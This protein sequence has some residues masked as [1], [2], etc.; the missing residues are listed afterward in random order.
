ME[1]AASRPRTGLNSGVSERNSWLSEFVDLDAAR[2]RSR[3]DRQRD[4]DQEAR[5]REAQR[6]EADPLDAVGERMELSPAPGG[7]SV[8]GSCPLDSVDKRPPEAL[9]VRAKDRDFFNVEVKPAIN[10]EVKPAIRSAP[11]QKPR[12]CHLVACGEGQIQAAWQAQG[13]SRI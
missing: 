6:D 1:S 4:Q 11:C 9:S 7:R 3:G 5:D 8:A 2:S 13:E 12:P 10:T